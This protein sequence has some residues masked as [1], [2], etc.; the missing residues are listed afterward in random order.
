MKKS[1]ILIIASFVFAGSMSSSAYLKGQIEG[2]IIKQSLFGKMLSYKEE[3][4]K[5]SN[6]LKNYKNF[7][8]KQKRDFIKGCIESLNY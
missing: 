3:F 4:A 2:R 6:A 8:E 5:C 1:I 7:N